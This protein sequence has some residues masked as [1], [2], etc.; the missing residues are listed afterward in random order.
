MKQ[1]LAKVHFSKGYGGVVARGVIGVFI[2][3]KIGVTSFLFSS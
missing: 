1:F 2:V 3:K